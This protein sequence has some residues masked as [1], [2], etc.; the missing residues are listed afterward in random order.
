MKKSLFLLAGLGALILGGYAAS[1]L[2]ATEVTETHTVPFHVVVGDKTVSDEYVLTDTDTLPDPVTVTQTVTETVEIPPPTS[3]PTT[4]TDTTPT[5]TTPTTPTNPTENN[6]IVNNRRWTCRGLVNYDLVKVT[7]DD[8]S[9]NRTDAVLLASGCTGHIGRLEIDTNNADGMHVGAFAHDITID[10]GYI[11]SHGV[12]SICGP[13]HVDGIQFLGGQRITMRNLDI[14]YPTATN[15]AIY[16]NTGSGG[17]DR[18]TDNV[19]EGCTIRRGSDR[20]RVVRIY[21]ST[22]SGV[23]NSTIYYCGNRD[24]CEA[25]GRNAPAVD[26]ATGTSPH[27]TDPVN[28][29]NTLILTGP[30]DPVTF[31]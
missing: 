26:I 28:E 11:H 13:V 21:N 18:P 29:N 30:N 23:R 25:G 16:Y 17:Q 8:P 31:P 2:M 10:S 4:P 6:L 27:A 3:P 20:N 24:Q 15:A 12:C 14:N 9:L 1:A 22:R 19:C 5:D 7:I